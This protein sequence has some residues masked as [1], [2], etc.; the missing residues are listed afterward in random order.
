MNWWF[1]SL[2]K[3]R[4]ALRALAACWAGF[5][6]TPQAP[7]AKL[8]ARLRK[9]RATGRYRYVRRRW[10]VLFGIVDWIGQRLRAALR[11]R[12]VLCSDEG[13]PR[14]ILLV[15][16]DHLG[17]AVITAAVLPALRAR[18]PEA[19]IEVLASSWNREVF[20][21]C[22]EIDFVHVS[23]VNR[24]A[25]G[26][27]PQWLLAQ[28]WWGLRLRRRRFDLAVD[29]RGELPLAL[30]LW[31]A[32]AKRR[33]GWDC[34]GGG[35]LLTDSA[36]YVPGRP[37]MESRLELLKLIGVDPPAEIIGRSPW[38]VP[39]AAAR[40]SVAGRLGN[41]TSDEPLVVIH[42]GAGTTAKR[43]PTPHWREL[44]GRLIVDFGP[45]IVLIG[46]PREQS[47]AADIL[48]SK[49]WPNVN[50][51]TGRL[52]IGETA[53]LLEQADLFIGADSGPAHLAA[54][55]GTPAVVL[56]SGTNRVRQWRPWGLA[57]VVKHQVACSPCHLK[58]C[59]FAS[60]PCM[61]EISPSAVMRRA[62]AVLHVT[63]RTTVRRQ[64]LSVLGDS[65]APEDTDR[66][67]GVRRLAVLFERSIW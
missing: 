21:A 55:V 33:V 3:H 54:A 61:T 28:A 45:Q 39:P 30:I 25:R 38:F 43:W 50:N 10:H 65:W 18:Y 14:S 16:L 13:G 44:I 57:M 47:L 51:W 32:G 29:M 22:G 41:A 1:K 5:W 35:F 8:Q 6:A 40:S 37:E 53:A 64:E 2:P 31:L 11:R 15:Q 7:S 4:S 49:N 62:G 24:F 52:T 23:R 26:W 63:R 58:R 60:H 19:R 67:A 46:G 56:F 17:D 12:S 36:L 66:R 20:D 27:H 34:G 59:P 9:P 48:E 42:V